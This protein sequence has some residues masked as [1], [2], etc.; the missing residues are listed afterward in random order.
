MSSAKPVEA[1]QDLWARV[2]KSADDLY[3]TRDTYFPVNPLDKIAKLQSQSQLCLSLLDSIPL[4]ERK[5]T[6]QR[7]EYEYL[8]GKILDVLPDYRKEAEDHLSKSVKLNPSLADA[9][10]CLGNCI[11]KKG[12]LS[13]AKN[14]FHLALNKGPNKKILCLLSML[15]RRMS[16]GAENQA[17]LVEESIQHAKDAISLDVKDGYS[18]YNLG[19]AFLTSFFM[20]GAWDHN[21][22]LHSLKAYQNAEKDER[23]LSN[24]DLYFNSATVNKYLENY[25]RALSGF[26]AAASKDPSLNASEE[27]QKMVN[28]LDKLENSLKGQAKAKRLASLASSLAAVNLNSSFKRATVDVLSDGLNK[29]VA[30]VGKVLL[31]VKHENVT[32]LV[33]HKQCCD[34]GGRSANT[35]GA[36]S[37]LYRLFLE[38]KALPV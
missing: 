14:C 23:M 20:T 13:S 9:W 7:A 12:E 5:T 30:I 1:E 28:L 29:A 4:E 18:W 26:E 32:P 36:F 37:S 25:E 17:E 33:R 19:N 38:G 16:Q 15:E 3:T 22:L 6:G 31:F 21:K 10:L 11:W 27:V 34:K 24:P 35:F 2:Q 8:K